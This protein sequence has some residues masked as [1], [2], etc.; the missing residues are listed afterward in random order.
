[1]TPIK[2][3]AIVAV[4]LLL[5]AASASAQ[6][7]PHDPATNQ[8]VLD[9]VVSQFSTRAAGWQAVVMSAATWLFWTLGTISLVWTFGFM[10]LRRA[11]IA[12][13]FAEF[14]RFILFF[15]FMLWLL[16]NGPSFAGS[17]I[18]SL[19]QLGDQAAGTAGASPSGIVDLGFMIWK[20]GVRNLSMLSPVD[21]A[22]GIVLSAVILIMLTAIA[23][24]I[25][26]LL[27]SGWILMYAGI[28]FL[29][30]GGSRWTSDIAIN[31]YKTVLSVAVQLFAMSLIV[32]IGINLLATF[33]AKMS[34]GPLN[35]DELGV[36]LVAC[37]TLLLLVS[38]V[39]PLLGGIISGGGGGVHNMGIGAIAGAALGATSVAA[40]VGSA[41]VAGMG[42]G[43]EALI[44][45]YQKANAAGSAVGGTGGEWGEVFSSAGAGNSDARGQS[46]LATAMGDTDPGDGSSLASAKGSDKQ[47]GGWSSAWS[48]RLPRP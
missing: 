7:S 46:P 35:F 15:G 32:G 25:L 45:A 42:R 24:N 31:Y 6:L 1:M 27:I 37:F 40:A 2:A 22:V 29:G 17:I 16:R 9:Q 43:A 26:L 36:M 13:F 28:F 41:G 4:M 30:F 38:R 44:E 18:R 11:D 47:G 34:K 12:E 48:P 20:Q 23:V 5:H 39:P 8:G 10:A 21:S 3:V 33:Y 14:I 19:Q